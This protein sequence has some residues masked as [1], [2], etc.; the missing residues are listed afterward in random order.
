MLKMKLRKKLHSTMMVL[1]EILRLVGNSFFPAAKLYVQSGNHTH[2]S[3]G[4]LIK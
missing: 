3:Y 1:L 4:V 2:I